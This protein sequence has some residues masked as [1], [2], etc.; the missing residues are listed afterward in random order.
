MNQLY[1]KSI[2]G[3]ITNMIGLVES[4]PYNKPESPDLELN[5][6][7]YGEGLDISIERLWAFLEK[8]EGV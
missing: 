2:E 4:S 7:I 1:K 6:G 3:K 5:T 8:R